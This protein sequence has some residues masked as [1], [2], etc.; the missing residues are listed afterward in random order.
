MLTKL[1]LVTLLKYVR[2]ANELLGS[3]VTLWYRRYNCNRYNQ[4]SRSLINYNLGRLW[5]VHYYLLGSGN[6]QPFVLR[7]LNKSSDEQVIDIPYNLI[8]TNIIYAGQSTHG[9]GQRA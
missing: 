8:N 2:P 1:H 3:S 7:G 4:C 9:P 5:L 6:V